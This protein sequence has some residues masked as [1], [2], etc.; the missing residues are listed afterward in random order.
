M[1][2]KSPE[3]ELERMRARI[4][5]SQKYL[6]RDDNPDLDPSHQDQLDKNRVPGEL[7]AEQ[8]SHNSKRNDGHRKLDA[9][10]SGRANKNLSDT[11]NESQRRQSYV[12]LAMAAAVGFVVGALWK[13]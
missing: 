4:A 5:I 10:R 7:D 6:K 2:D 9:A 3:Q 8:L 13:T 12:S 11:I 1:P